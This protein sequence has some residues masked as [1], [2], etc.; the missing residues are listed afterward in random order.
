[1]T[2]DEEND[3]LD[4][5]R[6]EEEWQHALDA[7]S[8]AVDAGARSHTLAQPDAAAATE[9]IRSH[10]QWLSSFRPTLHKLFPRRRRAD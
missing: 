1:V 8:A 9:G 2:P 10:R 7:A 5:E 6:L 3:R 4:G